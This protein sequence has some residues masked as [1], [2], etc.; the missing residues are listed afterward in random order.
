MIA[1]V[2]AHDARPA[3]ATDHFPA[4]IDLPDGFQPEGIESQGGRLYAGSLATGAI[5]QA[6]SRTGAGRYLVAGATGGSAAGLHIDAWGRLWVA[7]AASQTI[8]VYALR[9]G[10]LLQ[11][12]TFPTTG[13]INDLTI[14]RQAIY[15]TDSVNQQLAV[16]PLGRGGRLPAT[17]AAH[18]LALTGDIVYGAGF[19]ANGI[20]ARTGTLILVQSNTGQLFRVDPRTGVAR[21]IDT[22]GY[23]VSFGDGLVLRGRIL[24]VIRNQLAIVAVLR[25]S[26]DLSHAGL[27]GEI[28]S[29][30]LAFPTTG[31]IA[32][33]RLWVVNARFDVTPTPDTEYWIS[34]LPLAP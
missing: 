19:N 4:R 27:V 24:Y 23:N 9:T 16:V 34:R 12:Y 32:L 31:T 22:G 26:A 17:T 28:T 15:A 11:T 10:R 5:W 30:G 25:L 33:G 14:T 20:V 2:A 7:G 18:T 29:M 13:F 21:T 3:G 6:D 8:K 1:P